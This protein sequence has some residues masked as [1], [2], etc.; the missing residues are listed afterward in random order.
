M[1]LEQP[2]SSP[3]PVPSITK[4]FLCQQV[5]ALLTAL[6][7]WE[8]ELCKVGEDC[9]TVW[10]KRNVV[11]WDYNIAVQ[12]AMVRSLEVQGLWKHLSQLEAQSAGEVEG[13]Q[14]LSEEGML[15]AKVEA[16][17]WKEEWLVSKAALRLSVG[18]LS[19]FGW[20]FYHICVNPG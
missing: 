6:V 9:D 12:T 16:A 4:V 7:A 10:R 18:A 5:E 19:P 11:Q 13:Q 1:P 8:G 15:W 20:G 17:R 3:K 14:V 2:L